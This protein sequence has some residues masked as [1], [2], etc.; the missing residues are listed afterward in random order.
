MLDD[1]QMEPVIKMKWLI[2]FNAS[3]GKCTCDFD[4]WGRCSHCNLARV[5][6]WFMP[7]YPQFVEIWSE[8]LVCNSFGLNY[9]FLWDIYKGL[10]T[11]TTPIRPWQEFK[12]LPSEWEFSSQ[13]RVD[14]LCWPGLSNNFFFCTGLPPAFF[15]TTKCW[16]QKVA[17][18]CQYPFY[19][20]LCPREITRGSVLL[21]LTW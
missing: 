14:N 19:S 1:I 12:A 13:R 9:L 18:P 3:S 8:T 4:P 10:L 6:V 2:I 15:P 16:L 5:L 7:E 21:S 17:A 20:H 11:G